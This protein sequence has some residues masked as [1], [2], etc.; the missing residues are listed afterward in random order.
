MYDTCLCC[1]CEVCIVLSPLGDVLA[2]Y[3]RICVL[4]LSIASVLDIEE[5]G[6]LCCD[7]AGMN[8]IMCVVLMSNLIGL[9]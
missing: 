2:R 4:T 9:K 5:R 1:I 6:I 8:C 3:I 7:V